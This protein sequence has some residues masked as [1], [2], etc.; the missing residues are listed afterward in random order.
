MNFPAVKITNTW[1]YISTKKLNFLT[2]IEKTV[3][4]LA[5]HCG[6]VVYNLMETLNKDQLIQYIR[7]YVSPIVH[8]GVLFCGLGARTKL[9]K[10]LLIQKH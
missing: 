8:Y 3:L 6:T 9:E 5:Q 1:A 7:S 4:K 2:H 10:I